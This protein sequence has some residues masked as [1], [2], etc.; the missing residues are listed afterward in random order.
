VKHRLFLTLLVLLSLAAGA[1]ESRAQAKPAGVGPGG[2]IAV[3]VGGSAFQADY[4]KNYLY[5]P[6]VWVDIQ[7]HRVWGIEAEARFLR[8]HQQQNVRQD[9]YLIGP[10]VAFRPI[11]WV[12]YVKM[13]VGLG[14]MTFPYNYAN[15]SYFVMAPGAGVEY[16]LG[17]KVRIRLLDVEYQVWPQFTFGT[18]KPYG[19]TA[20][21]SFKVF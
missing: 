15:G 6:T 11:G 4:G 2:Y 5:G 18:L 9:T 16:M 13:P 10:K 3:G 17:D 1:R 14:K 21:I 19:A 8:Y 12:P 7:P 20:G